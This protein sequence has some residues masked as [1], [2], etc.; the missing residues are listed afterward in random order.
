MSA[1]ALTQKFPLGA[2]PSSPFLDC[3]PQEFSGTDLLSHGASVEKELL[4]PPSP[5]HPISSQRKCRHQISGSPE[6][7]CLLWIS[8][9]QA[10][11]HTSTS[12]PGSPLSLHC[13]GREEAEVRVVLLRAQ[14]HQPIVKPGPAE[15]T[16]QPVHPNSPCWAPQLASSPHHLVVTS[17][18]QTRK[19]EGVSSPA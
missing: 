3:S 1:K 13:T 12:P 8:G 2:N 6:Q 18:T 16:A 11:R 5:L 15:S 10:L 4:L 9:S 19:K 14:R 17:P 7:W